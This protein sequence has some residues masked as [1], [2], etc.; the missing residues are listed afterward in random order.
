[1]RSLVRAASPVMMPLSSWD[2]TMVWSSASW[3]ATSSVAVVYSEFT[4]IICQPPVFS[5][6][7]TSSGTKKSGMP[8]PRMLW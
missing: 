2:F 3:F 8:L 1:M 7:R 4:I 5:M 6:L